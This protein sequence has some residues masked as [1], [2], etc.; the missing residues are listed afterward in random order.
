MSCLDEVRKLV[1]IPSVTGNEKEVALYLES[2]LNDMGCR[3]RLFEVAEDRFNVY[4]EIEG[5]EKKR[6]AL[7]FHGHLD[8]VPAYG[9]TAPFDS[10][11]EDERVYG[12][13]AVD[14]KGGVAAVVD[15]FER[16]IRR[17][18]PLKRS[19]VFVGVVDE[20]SEHRGSMALSEMG[21]DADFG[22][23]TEPSE[24]RIGVGCKGTAPIH[25]R[26][27][28][29]AAHGCRPW[30]GKNAVLAGMDIARALMEKEF[31]VI[32]IEGIGEVRGS[33]N[34]GKI[35]GGN[36]YNIVPD[37]CDLWFDRRLIPGET[38]NHILEE[39]RSVCESY[40]K[41][42]GIEV[43]TEIGRP[44]WNWEPVKK[45][46]LLP[47]LADMKS[48]A[49][50]AVVKAHRRATGKEPVFYFTDGYHEM[51]FLVND[52]GMNAI[53]YGPGD[54]SLCH[55][56]NEYLDTGQ[57]KICADMYLHLITELCG[58]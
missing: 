4:A 34:L 15:A 54:S 36:A 21:V 24:C 14:Q 26:V 58:T 32:E 48:G 10:R 52:L 1:S 47:A 41:R 23:I 45:R 38:Q 31:P 11:V 7:L 18:S 56:D 20:E 16:F 13:G 6:P 9:M 27:K 53:H 40:G 5:E 49:I 28:G 33:L 25:V 42:T 55:T 35:E 44:D 17:G 3:T 2:R 50:D 57:L 43:T 51:D 30:L 19:V 22:V 46:G 12:R 8:T 29:E 39:V 37:S